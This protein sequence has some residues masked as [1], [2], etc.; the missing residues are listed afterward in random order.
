MA[1]LDDE[2]DLSGVA[3][4]A[5]DLDGTLLGPA[6]A[7]SVRT[8]AAVAA[9]AD[10]GVEVVV[11]TGRGHRSA[12]PLIEPLTTVR[13]LIASNGATLYDLRRNEVVEH[14]PL[15][16]SCVADLVTT[17]VGRFGPVGLSWET[18]DGQYHDNSW[19]AIRRAHDPDYRPLYS[20]LRPRLDPAVAP[21]LKLM[22]AHGRLGAY[23]WLDALLPHVPDGVTAV[24]SGAP[25]VEVTA[26]EADKGFAVA[27]LCRR[28][29]IDRSATAAF[30]DQVN[31]VGMLSWVELG[32]AMANAADRVAAVTTWRAP[33]HAEDGV[34]Q[35]LERIRRHRRS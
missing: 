8:V 24:T 4:V 28:L 31:D 29:G 9:L 19:I 32:F 1:P 26:G 3:L 5:T 21:V 17:A 14:R 2:T 13:W 35:V 15:A 27:E 22:V 7:L 6:A 20:D 23:G 16:A 30:G 18:P 10:V 33:H 12:V 11:A 34:A 25:F